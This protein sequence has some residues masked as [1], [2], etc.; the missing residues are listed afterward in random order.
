[1]KK[2]GRYSGMVVFDE[3]NNEK[4]GNGGGRKGTT[5]NMPLKRRC[6]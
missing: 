3:A 1:M 2:R 4:G 6:P 5:C